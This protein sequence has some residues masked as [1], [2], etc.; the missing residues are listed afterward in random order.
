MK[1]HILLLLGIW[2]G[3]VLGLSFVEAPLKFQAP[4]ITTKLG[5][6]IGRLVFSTSNKIQLVFLAVLLCTTGLNITS[7]SKFSIVLTCCATIIL[8]FQT[9]YLLPALDERA[10]LLL[11]DQEVGSSHHHLIFVG[12]EIAKLIVLVLLYKNLYSSWEI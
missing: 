5:L 2:I 7:F 12:L 6:G 8:G 10:L 9:F 1:T 4:G 3:L 11:Q